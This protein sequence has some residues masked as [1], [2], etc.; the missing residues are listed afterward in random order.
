MTRPLNEIKTYRLDQL[1]YLV[2]D[3]GQPKFRAKQIYE[4][5]H[6]KHAS[7]Y[8]E[9]TNLPLALRAQLAEE[10]PLASSRI[11]DKRIS[12]DGTRKYIIEFSDGQRAETVGLPS[13]SG[14]A[15]RQRLTVC[16][17]TQ[18]G[19]PM[20]CAFCATGKEGF[21]RNLTASEIV[22][23]ILAVEEDFSQRVTNAVAM[24]QGEPFL[25]YEETLKA[26]RMINEKEGLSI[27]ARHITV[28]TCG[29]I[30]GIERFAKEPEQFTLAV[31]LHSAIQT[32][33]DKLMPKVANQPL[34]QLK[35][36]LES[37]IRK[38]NRRVTFEYLLIRDVNDGPEDLK[39][40][41]KFCEGILCHVNLLPVNSVENSQFK[42][43]K[44][45]VSEIW[46]KEFE[47]RHIEATFRKSRG[48]DISGAC[49]QLKNKM[50]EV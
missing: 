1:E 18:V 4:W 42:P 21:K 6:V 46:L 16:F 17:S 13:E 32:K 37:Y 45:H 39:E 34:D 23:Q 27:G 12:T 43:S 24:G 36:V 47:K 3:L 33:R 38:T 15:S 20:G 26:L 40:L 2:K 5:F 49:G 29:I 8:D 7:S 41:L 10:C 22:D 11:A 9:M 30:E 28:S 25:N 31:S 35:Q 48:A 50:S 14:D 19:C 44:K